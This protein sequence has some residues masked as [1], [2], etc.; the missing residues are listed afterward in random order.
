MQADPL[1]LTTPSGY[2]MLVT[3]VEKTGKKAKVTT[4]WGDFEGFYA[5]YEGSFV[6]HTERPREDD[7]YAPSGARQE[8]LVDARL[9]IAHPEGFV[10]EPATACKDAAYYRDLRDRKRSEIERRE[11]QRISN[12]ASR[13]LVDAEIIDFLRAFGPV[14]HPVIRDHV[15]PLFGIPDSYLRSRM[16]YLVRR[17]I[18][19]RNQGETTRKTTFELI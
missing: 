18:V 14:R 13:D 4:H 19:F 17:N 1:Y 5:P 3:T 8:P 2:P 15:L 11:A 10:A 12:S 6:E 9:L 16:A 7:G